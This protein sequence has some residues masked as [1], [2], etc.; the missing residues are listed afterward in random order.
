MGGRSTSVH[1]ARPNNV[2]ATKKLYRCVCTFSNIVASTWTTEGLRHRCKSTCAC[3]LIICGAH[4]D[5][6]R[7]TPMQ[8]WLSW[9]TCTS[10]ALCRM[11]VIKA[12]CR[13]FM[14]RD[15]RC[16]MFV[17]REAMPPLLKKCQ[18]MWKLLALNEINIMN[19]SR[20]VTLVPEQP[21]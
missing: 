13:M 16:W 20:T 14:R 1:L 15:A 2:H 4:P 7:L 17:R 19:I 10:T 6:I 11:F 12:R 18:A 5:A 21:L 3:K 9:L 8:S